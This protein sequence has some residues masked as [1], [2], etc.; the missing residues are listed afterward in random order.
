MAV[1]YGKSDDLIAGEEGFNK[2]YNEFQNE[3]DTIVK[4]PDLLI[5]KKED[6]NSDLG[7]DISKI[8]HTEI[9][10]YVKKSIDGLEIRS[11]AFLIGKYEAEMQTR[12]NNHLYKAIK[13]RNRI[14][15]DYSNLLE[16]PKRK[17]FVKIL[18]SINKETINAVSFRKP[19]W[20]S[21]NELQELTK[22]FKEL[23]E[24][25]MIVQKR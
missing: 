9:T 3:L 20:N 7:Y 22:L 19:N 23:K 13:I 17:H 8:D 16:H 1:R 12:T 2:F 11:S 21:T 4:R 18:K 24:S 14:L 5:F 6:F 15:T 25:I 10:K